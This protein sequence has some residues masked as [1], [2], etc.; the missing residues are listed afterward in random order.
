M[1]RQ[2]KVGLFVLFLGAVCALGQSTGSGRP[3]SPTATTPPTTTTPTTRPTFDPN[4]P[5]PF[6][7]SSTGII[8]RLVPSPGSRAT[9]DLYQNGARID[10]AFADTDG[11]FRFPRASSGG[12]YEI[13]IPLGPDTE[14][15][16]EI[17]FQAGHPTMVQ[18]NNS[19]HIVSTTTGKVAS[20]GIVSLANLAAPKKAVAEMDKGR[21]LGDKKKYDEAL[22]HL[23]KAVEIYP[24]YPEAFNEMGLIERRQTGDKQV[25]DK[26]AHDQQAEEMFR[27]AI[28]ADPKWTAPYLNLAQLQLNKTNYA[29]LLK[30][31]EK[32]LQ[33]DPSLAPAHFYGAVG[34]YATGKLDLAEKEAL[35]A[36]IS[37]AQIPQVHLILGN[38]YEARGNSPEA[39][40]RYKLFLKMNPT[41]GNAAKLTAHIAELEH[42]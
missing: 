25:G 32:V 7:T 36:E 28:D 18:I 12:R 1:K 2:I 21:E 16:E 9:I 24:K 33:L 20:S 3:S 29:E 27:K 23:R 31:T 39:V 8:G 11:T 30:T 35:A 26:E 37:V 6:G 5:D 4:N 22:Q 34:Y 14:F 38:I 13:R 19:S 17:Q 41:A 15:R 40:M 10:T 42:E